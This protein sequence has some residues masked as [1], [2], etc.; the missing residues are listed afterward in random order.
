M[1]SSLGIS[2]NSERPVA[3]SAVEILARIEECLEM[4]A[5][6]GQLGV[7]VIL[8]SRTDHFE[9]IL[10][11]ASS[12]QIRFDLTRRLAD[13]LRDGD[14]LSVPSGN[15]IWVALPNLESEAMA[16]IATT[17]LL[18]TLDVPF[19]Q[20]KTMVSVQAWGGLVLAGR[21]EATSIDLV[22]SALN[23]AEKARGVGRRYLATSAGSQTLSENQAAQFLKKGLADN[24][25]SVAYQPQ[26]D[27]ASKKVVGLEVLIRWNNPPHPGLSPDVVIHA[28]ERFGMIEDLT[29]HVANT[30]MRE[31]STLLSAFGIR[32]IWINI[33]ALMLRNNKLP[34]KLLQLT[35]LWSLKPEQIGFEVTES[36]LITDVEQSLATLHALVDMGFYLAID[37]F[38]TGYSSLSYLSRLPV[39]ELKIDKVFVQKMTTSPADRQIVQAVIDLAHHFKLMVVAE[40]VEDLD[41]LE[42]LCGMKCDQVQGYVYSRPLASQALAAWLRQQDKPA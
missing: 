5:F 4:H 33:S 7:L 15:E 34:A 38:G 3:C 19:I 10:N 1:S 6:S 29:W 40:G 18:D 20:G 17:N 41:T 26:V 25:L 8:L 21:Q 24:F 39:H 42:S 2:C 27:L 12:E 28:A 31:Y 32:K 22:K 16:H 14:L 30:A 36:A 13:R 23:L 35:D 11:L 37:D 9:S